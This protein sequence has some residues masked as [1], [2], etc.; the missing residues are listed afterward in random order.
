MNYKEE[1]DKMNV[2]EYCSALGKP[3]RYYISLGLSWSSQYLHRDGTIHDL[4]GVE[5]L[6][7]TKQ[8]AQE[9]LDKCRG[10]WEFIT[11]DDMMI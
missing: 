8:E 3:I 6:W 1:L 2:R 10:K 4:C 5:N 7:E 9:F 11:E